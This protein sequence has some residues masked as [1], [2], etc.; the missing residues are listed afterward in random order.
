MK[1]IEET[2]F[3]SAETIADVRVSVDGVGET[4]QGLER[5]GLRVS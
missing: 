1:A 2:V 5:K 4:S 3:F